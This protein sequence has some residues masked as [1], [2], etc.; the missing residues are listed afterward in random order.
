MQRFRKGNA[1]YKEKLFS[2]L[3]NRASLAFQ[4]KLVLSHAF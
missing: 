3:A 2:I 4:I 1:K